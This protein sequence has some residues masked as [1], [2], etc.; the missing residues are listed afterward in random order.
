MR[1]FQAAEKP[2][3]LKGHVFS[4]A[5]SGAKAMRA[6]APQ[7]RFSANSLPVPHFSAACLAPEGRFAPIESCLGWPQTIYCP[8]F[9]LGHEVRGGNAGSSTRLQMRFA[10]DDRLFQAVGGRETIIHFPADLN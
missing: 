9:D 3:A 1:A 2:I 7:G 4:R 10:L 8:E 5:V 6:L